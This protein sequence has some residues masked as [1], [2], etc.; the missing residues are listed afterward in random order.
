MTVPAVRRDSD[1]VEEAAADGLDFAVDVADEAEAA[2]EKVRNV[3]NRT[4][5]WRNGR[6]T[7]SQVTRKQESSAIRIKQFSDRYFELA[8][9]HGK[10]LS[11]Y[12]VFDEPVLIHLDEQAYLIEP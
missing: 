8:L 6:W 10:K 7:D 3:G 4:F 5:Y 9:H 11:R 12:L 2:F 1:V